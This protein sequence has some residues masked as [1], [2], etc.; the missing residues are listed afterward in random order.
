MNQAKIGEFIAE[1]RK[2]KKMTQAG[3]GDIV[4]VTG[5]AVSRWERGLNLPDTGNN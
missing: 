2:E 3:L 1:L 4:G 5:K